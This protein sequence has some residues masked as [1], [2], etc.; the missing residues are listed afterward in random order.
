MIGLYSVR[1]AEKIAFDDLWK[2]SLDFT[3]RPEQIDHYLM[4]GWIS[5][6]IDT[7]YFAMLIYLLLAKM[8]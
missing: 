4:L 2:N 3:D 6:A 1:I 7:T 5:V 8:V